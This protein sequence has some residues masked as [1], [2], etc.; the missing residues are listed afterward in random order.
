MPLA[1]GA[2]PVGPATANHRRGD[3]PCQVSRQALLGELVAIAADRGLDAVGVTTAEPFGDARGQIES[4]RR[5]GLDGG[6]QFTYRNPA[7]STDP[8]RTLED[9]RSLVVA[10]RRYPLPDSEPTPPGH[11]RIAAYAADDHYRALRDGLGAVAR[12]LERDGY[13]AIV[14]ADDNAL[15][16][17]AAAE[18]AGIGWYAKN[19]NI[20]VGTLGSWFILGSVLTDAELPPSRTYELPRSHPA[21]AKTKEQGCGTC[22]RCI[23]A[24]PT[25]AIVAPG[26]I[27]SRR[28]LAWLLQAEGAFPPEHRVALG[29]RIYGCD[30]CQIVCPVNLRSARRA[31]S[32]RERAGLATV[33]PRGGGP[34]AVGSGAAAGDRSAASLVDLIELL[35]SDGEQL[36]S[37]YGRWYVPRRDPRYLRRNALVVLANTGDGEDRSTARALAACL[38]SDD[39]LVVAHAIW[40]ARA[41]G[42]GEMVNRIQPRMRTVVAADP[43]VVA[44]LDRG[45][46]RAAASR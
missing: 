25:A 22:T 31:K 33:L 14:L 15:V 16:D 7:R 30:E 4:C 37:R 8:R 41:L 5:D 19:T 10:A 43:M 6:M 44:E 40:A 21:P 13:R 29:D 18:R 28:C 32:S 9:A 11:G 3:L 2:G 34:G 23:D 12:R 39:P 38:S 17:R 35:E 42:M 45:A 1:E 24:C 36:M 46:E 26:V 20:M 27:D